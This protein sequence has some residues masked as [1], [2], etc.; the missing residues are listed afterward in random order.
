MKTI[1]IAT[2]FSEHARIAGRY[3][4]TLAKMLDA[5]L[6]C[7]HATI[8]TE[9]EP[10]A[11]ELAHGQLEEF[12]RAMQLEI[13]HKRRWLEL[14]SDEAGREGVKAQ[15]HLVD[16][17]PAD[18]ICAAAEEL[19]ADLVVI[20]SHGYTGLKRLLLGSVAERVVRHCH[21]SILVARPPLIDAHGFRHILVPTDFGDSSERALEQA[22][23]LAARDASIDLL[24]CWQT[25]ELIDGTIDPVAV[26]SASAAVIDEI[27]RDAERTGQSWV[28]KAASG[29]RNVA[30]HMHE[31]RPTH[32]VQSFIEE[33]QRPYD[34]VAVGTHGR[35]GIKRVLM[36]SVAE[37]TVRYSP[38]SVL[39]AR[40]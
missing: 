27:T 20:G 40:G 3:A 39:V 11:Y 9:A 10:N 36:G 26:T 29:E 22:T 19:K 33:S 28:A 6:V 17:S 12:R 35:T 34:L 30:F 7:M 37:T 14:L 32:G 1:L 16:G 31:G 2:D 8:M 24:H 25:S 38:C 18:A 4:I 15:H 23:M 21:S 13:G 5:N